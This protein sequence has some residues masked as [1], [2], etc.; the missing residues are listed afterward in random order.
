VSPL[1]ERFGADA[2]AQIAN[3]RELAETGIAATLA[4]IKRTAEAG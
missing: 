1:E 4:A 3:R 2:P